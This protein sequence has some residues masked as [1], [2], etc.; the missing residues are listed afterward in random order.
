[1][2]YGS[3]RFTG[4]TSNNVNELLL[5]DIERPV[6]VVIGA[7]VA[8]I[9]P[10]DPA[11]ILPWEGYP[12]HQESWLPLWFIAQYHARA[13]T[14]EERNYQAEL[15]A[16]VTPEQ[17]ALLRTAL[18]DKA[19][20]F[21]ADFHGSI[22]EPRKKF[23]KLTRLAQDILLY[24]D[25]PAEPIQDHD[26]YLAASPYAELITTANNLR[27]G[28]GIERACDVV[29]RLEND[30]RD[31]VKAAGGVEAVHRD[32]N[33]LRQTLTQHG[34]IFRVKEPTK[35]MEFYIDLAAKP[36]DLEL[37][38]DEHDLDVIAIRDSVQTPEFYQI[39][40]VNEHRRMDTIVV[41]PNLEKWSV[42]TGGK[43][44]FQPVS[45]MALTHG[46]PKT[47]A[48]TILV[49]RL[50]ETI[51]PQEV[52][53]HYLGAARDFLD[54]DGFGK[55]WGKRRDSELTL[56]KKTIP[57][58]RIGR[59]LLPRAVYML[60]TN[61]FP[62]GLTDEALF[63]AGE[64][65]DEAKQ[66]NHWFETQAADATQDQL[67]AV[68]E[69]LREKLMSHWDDRYTEIYQTNLAQMNKPVNPEQ[70]APQIEGAPEF[71]PGQRLA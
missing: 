54:G 6:K 71:Q 31:K 63:E 60:K 24:L 28:E 52:A 50:K 66:I 27:R 61:E 16:R 49:D 17:K 29:A 67:Q 19:Q 3:L 30:L 7:D 25:M 45:F 58:H 56:M 5:E 35:P 14:D 38:G 55:S 44:S 23:K 48:G 37:G 53:E 41:P 21:L 15:A 46:T 57:L 39:D 10:K 69:Q 1:M 59:D 68:A 34:D 40:R 22:D 4:T 2:K 70:I 42:V 8:L 43:E 32:Y 33:E 47:E 62:G 26:A 51:T 36:Y 64:T 13:E 18:L 12:T 11:K 65:A 9:L 20:D